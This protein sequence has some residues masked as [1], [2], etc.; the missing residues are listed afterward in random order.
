MGRGWWVVAGVAVA[1]GALAAS[2]DDPYLW[3]E[4]VTG[5][6]ALEWV[7]ATSDATLAELTSKPEYAEIESK[8]LEILDSKDKIA[9]VSLIGDK[10]YNFWQDADHPRGIWRRTTLDEYRKADPAWELVL[11][12][13]A[14]GASEGENWVW[15]GASCLPPEYARCLVSVSRGGADAD[16]TREFDLTT[17]AFVKDG[18]FL[19]EAKGGAAWVDADT[20]LVQTD[21]G[22]GSMTDSGY[23]RT[24]RRLKRGA[25]LADAEIVFEGQQPDVAVSAWKDHTAGFE[26][27]FVNRAITFY[28]SE[29]Y[30]NNGG[31]LVKLDVPIDAEPSV[32]REWLAV[33]LRTDW[34]VGGKTFPA[35]SLVVTRFDDFMAGKREFEALFTPSERTALSGFTVTKSAVVLNVLDNV[36]SKVYIA[37]HGDSGWSSAP[38]AGLPDFGTIGVSAVDSER[39]DDVWVTVT[40][41]VTPTTLSLG[42]VNGGAVERLKSM[43]SFFDASSMEISQHEAIS[44]DGTRVP[45]F[46]VSKK[47]MKTNGKNPTLLYGYGG[48]E[49]SL[50]PSYSGSIGVAWLERG[51]TYVLANIRGGGEFGPKWHQAALK[52]NRARAY[53]DFAAVAEHLIERKVTKPKKLGIMGGSNGGLLVGN[54]LVR[55][56]DLFGAVVCQVPLLDMKRYH[57]LLAGASW[58]GEY[59]NPDVPEEWS[60]IQTFSPY[61]LVREDVRYPPTLFLTSTRDDRVHPGHAR[62][63][64]ARMIEQGHDVRYWENTEGGHGGAANNAQRAKMTALSWTFLW[65]EL[66]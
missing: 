56:P 35:G 55:R 46:Q 64:V 9:G 43:P 24:V 20:L 13:D 16:V 11:D 29:T 12:L 28:T 21:F 27:E 60:Y 62:K 5:E 31:S 14:L 15:H 45:Y 17:K 2:S 40:D 48:F 10:Y 23:P 50:T 8:V 1:G 30:W 36:R 32:F 19:P 52:E 66:G 51:G 65:T 26:R 22:E 4:D 59:G 34:T 54:M 7:G 49:V 18:F 57:T 63:M 6:K 3:L 58:M 33:N 47:G 41:F 37:K 25:S 44:A 61:Q 53:E 39:S 38:M 42:S